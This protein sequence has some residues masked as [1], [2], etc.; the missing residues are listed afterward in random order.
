LELFNEFRLKENVKLR[1]KI[2]LAPLTTWAA[3]DNLTISDAEA[4]YY[5][6]RSKE[7]GMVITGCTFFQPN[8]Q[9]FENEFYA[10]SD[11]FIPSLKKLADSIKSQGA[12]AI[13]QIFHGG[14]MALPNNGEIVAPSAV[15]S[16]HNIFE[17]EAEMETPKEMTH[18]EIMEFIDGFYETTKRAI[19]AGFDGIEIHGANKFLIQ[20]FFSAESNRRTDEW[21][22][23]IEKRLRFPLEIIKAANKARTEYSNEEFIIGY[24]FS[25]EETEEQGITLDDTLY[26]ADKLANQQIDYLHVS[27]MHYKATSRRD[28]SDKRII[29]KLL[30]KKINGR[31]PLIGVGCIKS[32]EDAEDA[33][34]SVGYDL[35][36]IGQVIVTE[37]NWVSKIQS[38]EEIQTYIDMN[39]F[40][41]QAIPTNM[42]NT[43]AGFPGWFQIKSGGEFV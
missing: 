39:N 17:M 27:L 26:L 4:D 30:A 36:S 38:G 35:I 16:K 41:K 31:K 14:R 29:G 8:G 10:G 28:S 1:N 20:Q 33:F 11:D 15:K 13:L 32:R 9:A 22:G 37:P 7:A 24:R 21:G 5:T 18:K 12:K 3:N 19:E 6:A 40:G 43:I 42:V 2:V 34:D 23:T 25:P